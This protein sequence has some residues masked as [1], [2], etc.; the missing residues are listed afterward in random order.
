M[1]LRTLADRIST[2]FDRR[3]S[4][5]SAL[6]KTAIA[7]SAFA[8]API[9]YLVRPGH[10]VG[11]DRAEQLRVRPVPR[12]LHR[13][14][15]RD[16]A[17]QQQLPE[18]HLRRRLVEVHELPGRRPVPRRGRPLL[19]RLQPDPRPDVP[20][21]LPVCERR[22]QQAPRRLQPLPL[23]AVQHPDPRHDRGRVPAD[24][25]PEPGDRRRD[26]L[27]R[28]RDGRRQHL[29]ARGGLPRGSRR[30]ASGR[31]RS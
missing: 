21:R 27:Q 11:G 5:R 7:G 23:R 17:R 30:P 1:S 18:R 24:H 31:R 15:L 2:L 25:L 8:V 22:L 29:H 19:H 6:T 12:R 13:V 10:G 14:L 9:R 28:H 20:R 4:R 26:E 16:R 3:V